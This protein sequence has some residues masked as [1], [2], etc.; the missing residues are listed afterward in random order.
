MATFRTK[1]ASVNEWGTMTFIAVPER[2]MREFD[3][4]RRVPVVATIDGYAYRTTIC[5][6]GNGPCIPVRRSVREAA[7]IAAGRRV[8]VTL[9]FDGDERTVAVPAFLAKAMTKAERRAFDS[10]SYSHRKEYV[11]WITAAKKP[12]TRDRRVEKTREK[13]RERVTRAAEPPV[14]PPQVPARRRDGA[15]RSQRS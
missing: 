15:D 11:D 1:L 9:A 6:M 10:M 8:T 5:D 7:G 12:E 2:A 3:G 13:L 4:H 14:R